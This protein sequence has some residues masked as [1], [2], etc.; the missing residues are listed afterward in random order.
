M[1][2][3]LAKSRKLGHPDA[4][5]VSRLSSILVATI[6]EAKDKISQIDYIF[7]SQLYPNFQLKSQCLEKMYSEAREAA[8]GAYNEKKKDMLLQI[9]K[10]QCEKQQIVEENRL[11]KLE[12]AKFINKE[13]QSCKH[14]KELQI[15]LKHK[16]ME[17]NGGREVQ[18][19][20]QKLLQSKTSVIDSYENTV[21]ELEE[22]KTILMGNQ[23][24]LEVETEELRLQLMKKSKEVDEIKELQNKL[25]KINQSN[26]SLVIQ[27][28]TQL[29]EY[30]EK[31]N[32]HIS[33][34]EN[35]ENKV[36]ELL[37]RLREKTEEVDKGKKLQADLL[38]KIE[39]QASEIMNNEHLLS[40]YEKENSVLAIKV[41]NLLRRADALQKELEKKN[42][43]LD[44]RRQLQEQLLQRSDSFNL[45]RIMRGHE[46]EE[47][48]E[49][50]K[51]LLD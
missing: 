33:K 38:K 30:E 1:E 49:E 43:G 11:M 36:D 26:V 37:S 51:R 27:K 34:L 18:Q 14:F 8:E 2:N 42:D 29:K 12:I 28:E 7:C 6:K 19:N 40:K 32:I 13:S 50:R 45:E 4:N 15:K 3:N 48:E 47:F 20:Y 23:R 24:S 5:Y 25:V 31:T 22:K 10:L 44:E 35:T 21:K 46:L 9:E 17:V 39:L 16:S 41:D